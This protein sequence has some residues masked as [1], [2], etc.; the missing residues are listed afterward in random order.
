MR[1]VKFA[2]DNLVTLLHCGAEFFPALEAAID[3]AKAEIYLETYIFSPDETGIRIEAAL[4]RA[5]TRGVFVNVITDWLGTGKEQSQRLEREFAGAGVH[6]RSYNPWFRRGTTRLHRKLCVVD[7]QVG[8]VG[9]LNINDDMRDDEDFSVILPAPRWDFAVSVSGP[10]VAEIHRE[11]EAQWVSLGRLQLNLR[12]RLEQ[13]K[14]Y[15]FRR[16]E[17]AAEPAMAGLVVRDNLRNRRTIER[18]Y[19]QALGRARKD[20][21]LANPYFAPGRKLRVALASA[22]QR[23]VRVTLLLGVGQ[24]R[25]QDAVARS[26]YPKLLESGVRIVEYRKTQLHGKVAVR[27]PVVNSIYSSVKQVSDTLFSSSGNAF[28]KAV[29]VQYPHQG[30]WTIA[31][32]TGTPGGDVANH[33]QGDY[34]SVYVPTTPNP[35]S[36]FFLMMRKSDTVELDMTVD[37]ALKY[38][39]SMGVVAPEAADKK[40]QAELPKVGT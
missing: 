9:G 16:S 34:I 1:S 11:M 18:A 19:L 12:S 38:I 32:L 40:V 24:F 25:L 14:T 30:S 35:T 37:A 6:F 27:I 23:G 22:A 7:R 10:L 15:R 33:L 8:F 20:A 13:I 2:A 36:G 31:F 5:A 26:Y 3:A 21:W 39:V 4:K 17:V 29:L 28:R